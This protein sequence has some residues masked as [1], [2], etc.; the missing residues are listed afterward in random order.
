M[1][2]KKPKVPDSG[3]LS[4]EQLAKVQRQFTG[5]VKNQKKTFR[6]QRKELRKQKGIIKRFSAKESAN[7]DAQQEIA[8]EQIT[9]QSDQIKQENLLLRNQSIQRGQQQGLIDA[10][11]ANQK[12]LQSSNLDRARRSNKFSTRSVISQLTRGLR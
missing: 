3:A 11:N 2:K 4:D 8:Q 5:L 10:F 7:L 12:N 1:G 9:A 6:R